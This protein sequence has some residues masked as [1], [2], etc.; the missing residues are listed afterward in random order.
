MYKNN[1]FDPARRRTLKAAVGVTLTGM[2]ATSTGFA[3]VLPK[4]NTAEQAG[5]FIDCKL[6]CRDDDSRAYLLMHN[7]TDADIVTRKFIA[8]TIRY[9]NMTLNMAKA[10]DHPV[11]VKSQDRIMVRL[12]L[13]TGRVS[14][15]AKGIIDFGTD[16]KYPTVGTRAVD[17]P[18]RVYQGVGI[19]DTLP[20]HLA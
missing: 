12:N 13:E 11:T 5:E 1:H 20:V 17:M 10:F 14:Y 9:E 16:K 3:G 6:I 4:F 18:V 8:Q 2:A 19:I 7:K 15:N